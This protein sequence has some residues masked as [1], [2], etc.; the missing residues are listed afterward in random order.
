MRLGHARISITLD[1]YSHVLPSMQRE[2]AERLDR[3]FASFDP[4]VRLQF[5]YKLPV[6]EGQ[7]EPVEDDAFLGVQRE[8]EWSHVDSNHGPPACEAG[9]LTC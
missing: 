7:P 1:I 9:A 6:E 8:S 4:K 2:A 5:G 3:L